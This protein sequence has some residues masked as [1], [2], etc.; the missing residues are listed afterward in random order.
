[1]LTYSIFLEARLLTSVQFEFSD[2][3]IKPDAAWPNAEQIHTSAISKCMSV[4]ALGMKDGTVAVWDV[5]R[6]L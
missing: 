4:L 5:H 1:M 6:G 2:I 3:E